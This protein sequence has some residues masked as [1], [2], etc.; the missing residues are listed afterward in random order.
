VVWGAGGE[1]KC[2][3]VVFCLFFSPCLSL[4]EEKEERSKKR[5]KHKHTDTDTHTHTHTR[6]I[7]DKGFRILSGIFGGDEKISYAQREARRER[8]E[9]RDN[10]EK[11]E[12][13]TNTHEAGTN[14]IHEKR[15]ERRT[16]KHSQTH[17][18]PIKDKGVRVQSRTRGVDKQIFTHITRRGKRE[19]RERERKKQKEHS[20]THRHTHKHTHVQ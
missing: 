11:K 13:H 4:R 7:K 3:F 14:K 17:T 5:E 8:R 15:E 18:R 19:E 12:K 9:K 16:H 10:R 6:P 2:F 20:Q 1:E